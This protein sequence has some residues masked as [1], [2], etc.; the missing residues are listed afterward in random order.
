MH[1]Y[2]FLFQEESY[3]TAIHIYS[4]VS[5]KFERIWTNRKTYLQDA[6]DFEEKERKIENEKDNEK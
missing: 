6:T 1:I 2:H 5:L 3:E 4:I